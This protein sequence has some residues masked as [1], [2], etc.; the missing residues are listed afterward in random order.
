MSLVDQK[1]KD[2]VI[3]LSDEIFEFSS[4]LRSQGRKKKAVTLSLIFCRNMA[5]K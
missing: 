5:M 1:L 4:W 3:H 2:A